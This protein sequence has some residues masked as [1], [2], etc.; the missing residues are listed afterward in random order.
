MT[1]AECSLCAVLILIIIFSIL[2]QLNVIVFFGRATEKRERENWS[3][4]SLWNFCFISFLLPSATKCSNSNSSS[5]INS[6]RLLLHPKPPTNSLLSTDGILPIVTVLHIEYI[7]RVWC[8]IFQ[9]LISSALT[10]LFV[11]CRRNSGSF[12]L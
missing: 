4:D 10:S 11:Q 1:Y 5:G 2:N 8:I 12:N 7:I 3:V 6:F 9:F